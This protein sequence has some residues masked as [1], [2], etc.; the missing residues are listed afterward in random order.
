MVFPWFSYGFPM[1][2][3]W[4]SMTS[5]TSIW[6]HHENDMGTFFRQGVLWTRQASQKMGGRR[7]RSRKVVIYSGFMVGL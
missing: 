4:F 2:F 5:E 7:A 6:E 3:P 1:V